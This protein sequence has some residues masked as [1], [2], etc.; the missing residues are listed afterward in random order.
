ME[1]IINF[2]K[3]KN[4]VVTG[5]TGFKGAWLCAWLNRLGAKVYGTSLGS[6]KNKSLFYK[7][8]LEKKI[9]LKYFDIRDYKKLN[10]YINFSKPKIIFHLASQPIIY[11]SYKNPLLTFD[12]NYR[13]TLNV[14]EVARK[15]KFIRSLVLATTYS[16]YE[17]VDRIKYYKEDD[18]LGGVDPYS[19]SKVLAELI[20][21]A[22][23]ESFFKNKKRCGISSVRAGNVI[24]GGDQTE[25][26]LIPECINLLRKKTLIKLRN[27]DY[28]KPWQFVLEPLKGYLV[29]AKKQYENPS[30]YSSAWNFGN[31][32][33]SVRTVKQI[34]N[35]IIECWGSGK[36][37][38]YKN[39]S[40]FEQYDILLDIRKAKKRLKWFPTYSIKESVKLTAEWY[41]KVLEEKTPPEKV[42]NLQIENYMYENNWT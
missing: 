12:I 10:D 40:F 15:S 36:L 16:C 29:L 8:G 21:R 34:V 3:K 5:A 28:N 30:K 1:K 27:P 33:K 19:V 14:L 25:G 4:V 31:E 9:Y 13:G 37:K 6:K 18:A 7:L 26:R 22:Y 32:T 11:E 2:Y 38:Y 35:Q 23:R 20:I 41:Y 24:G 17:K 39:K 42:T